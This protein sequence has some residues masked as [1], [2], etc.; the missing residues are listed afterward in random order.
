MKFLL[1]E[2]VP[3]SIK[4]VIHDLGFE[5]FTLHDFDKLDIQNSEVS[6]LTLQEKAII[7][8]SDFLQLNQ[9]LQEKSCIYILKFIQE[10]QNF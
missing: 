2:N 1:D 7:I 5:V 8:D 6:K 4:D 3:I 9:I 10:I